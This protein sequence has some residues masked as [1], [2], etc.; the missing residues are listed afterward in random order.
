MA[1]RQ[2]HFKIHTVKKQNGD[3]REAYFTLY[4]S[5]GQVLMTSENYASRRNARYGV[6]AVRAAMAV[7]NTIVDAT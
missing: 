4:S 3:L 7:E 1:R 2:P 5:N 6:A